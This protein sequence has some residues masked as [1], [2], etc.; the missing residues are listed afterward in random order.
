MYAIDVRNFF[1]NPFAEEFQK[2]VSPFQKLP[3]D[4]QALALQ[5]WV[6]E[7]IYYEMDKGRF[8]LDEFWAY[9]SEVLTVKTGDCEDGAILLANLLRA[10]GVPYWKIRLTAGMTPLGAHAYVTYFCEKTNHWV[11]LDWCYQ[12]DLRAID[13]RPD[14][15]D[16][17]IYGEVWF[18]WNRRYAFSKGVKAEA[19]KCVCKN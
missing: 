2:I 17:P 16:S 3:H 12:L 14:Y 13:Q 10:C 8:G 5:L 6:I 18:S 1:V 7:N 4:D 19:M 15:K 11:A 9:P